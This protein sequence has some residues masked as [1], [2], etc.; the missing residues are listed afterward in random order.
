MT[1]SKKALWLLALPALLTAPAA[2]LLLERL[3]L[4]PARLERNHRQ[5]SIHLKS[6]TSAEADF[7]ANDRDWNHV[8]DFWT[9]D[10]AGLYYVRSHASANEPEI[11]LI[12]RAIAEADARSLHP[13]VPSPVPYEGYYFI[14]LDEDDCLAGS[15]ERFYRTE[16]GGTPAMG[17]VHNTSKFGFCAY[18]A[19]YGV[20]GKYT[21]LV[22]ENNTVFKSDNG[23]KPVLHFPDDS[24][25][26]RPHTDKMD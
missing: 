4:L 8:N 22:N 16:T 7:R 24:P 18:P 11:R 14:A 21:F 2:G 9:A 12:E 17:K 25:K 5:A 3:V 15:E 23:G 1:K 6:L 26:P 19:E 10:V 20:T 13:L